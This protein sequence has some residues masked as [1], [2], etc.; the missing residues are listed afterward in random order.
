M[1]SFVFS[2]AKK[3]R[4][5]KLAQAV[6]DM[7]NIAKGFRSRKFQKPIEETVHI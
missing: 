3:G 4:E 5:K 7:L 2:R 1:N 6:P